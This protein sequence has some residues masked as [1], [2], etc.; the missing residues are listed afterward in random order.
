LWWCPP[1]SSRRLGARI[2]VHN[3]FEGR[4]SARNIWFTAF[5]DKHAKCSVSN[6][7]Y[8]VRFATRWSGT[9]CPC[10]GFAT[11][12]STN[13]KMPRLREQPG[14]S[15]FV[16]RRAEELSQTSPRR[17]AGR[18]L[19]CRSMGF[20]ARLYLLSV[21]HSHGRYLLDVSIFSGMPVLRTEFANSP[22]LPRS[23][24]P[25]VNTF[26]NARS[27]SFQDGQSGVSARK[28]SVPFRPCKPTPALPSARSSRRASMLDATKLVVE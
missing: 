22:Q 17:R 9:I 7:S 20:P 6:R 5:G 15:V 2:S 14:R 8:S 19:R 23:T 21:V 24:A 11:T 18:I 28:Q 4:S 12:S 3:R 10:A 16:D 27:L 25:S 1:A 13:K 26:S